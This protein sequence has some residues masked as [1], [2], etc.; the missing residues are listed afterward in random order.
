MAGKKCYESGFT[1]LLGQSKQVRSAS[2]V[3]SRALFTAIGR[4]RNLHDL[5]WPDQHMGKRVIPDLVV[6]PI[7]EIVLALRWELL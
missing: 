5:S 2:T 4:Q 6:I 7:M 3:L 1:R